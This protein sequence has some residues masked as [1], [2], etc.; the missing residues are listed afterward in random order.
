VELGS[1]P[2]GTVMSAYGAGW[3]RER[4]IPR[5]RGKLVTTNSSEVLAFIPGIDWT[6]A[7]CG[8]GAIDVVPG[9]PAASET[10]VDCGGPCAPCAAGRRCYRPGTYAPDGTRTGSD[11]AANL[12]CRS[13]RTGQEAT[14]NCDPAVETCV[15]LA[16]LPS[17]T[18]ALGRECA[19]GRCGANGRCEAEICHNGKWDKNAGETDIDCG[20]TTCLKRCST[21]TGATPAPQ[22]CLTNA[23]CDGALG[24]RCISARCGLPATEADTPCTSNDGCDA[25]LGLRCINARCGLPATEAD[26]PCTS[27]DGC[28]ATKGLFCIQ[29]VCA[30]PGPELETC[31]ANTDCLSGLCAVPYKATKKVCLASGLAAGSVCSNSQQCGPT[32]GSC[33][34]FGGNNKGTCAPFA[35]D[36]V[37][38]QGESDVDC[39]GVG[40]APRCAA[41]RT[42]TGDDDCD[43]SNNLVCR[44]GKCRGQTGAVV[45]AASACI[46]GATRSSKVGARTVTTCADP[47]CRDRVRNGDETDVDV[48]G[49]ACPRA[50]ESRACRI[51]SD[52]AS[53]RCGVKGQCLKAACNDGIR[54]GNEAAV[55]CGGTCGPCNNG[56]P[57]IKNLVTVCPAPLA[58]ADSN[59]YAATR[60][61]SGRTRWT[62]SPALPA[63]ATPAQIREACGRAPAIQFQCDLRQTTDPANVKPDGTG[64]SCLS[65]PEGEPLSYPAPACASGF[66][67]WSPGVPLEPDASVEEIRSACFAADPGEFRCA[68]PRCDDGRVNGTELDRVDADRECGGTCGPCPVEKRPYRCRAASDCS[69]NIC[70]PRRGRPPRGGVLLGDCQR[71]TNRDGVRN[72][73]ET[74]VDCGG[75]G[76]PPCGIGRSCK[77][78]QDCAGG[79]GTDAAPARN[80]C[81][82][83]EGAVATD[84]EPVVGGRCSSLAAAKDGKKNGAETDIDC[85]GTSG[86]RCPATLTASTATVASFSCSDDAE[87]R[88]KTGNSRATCS[89]GVCVRPAVCIADSDCL[90]GLC[91]DRRKVGK[92]TFGV[93]N[94]ASGSDGIR[95]GLETGRDCGC[96]TRAQAVGEDG[97][98]LTKDGAPVIAVDPATGEQLCASTASGSRF[99]RCSLGGGCGVDD[100]CQTNL[101]TGGVCALPQCVVAASEDAPQESNPREWTCGRN[102]IQRC[103][104][105]LRCLGDV[106]CQSYK[107]FRGTC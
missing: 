40:S 74:D 102:C 52:C 103:A 39:G 80:G 51:D 98:P 31:T 54:N 15:C 12:F 30:A 14:A 37:R 17:G 16:P 7:G 83:A 44:S 38:N 88:S 87:C 46:S 75:T 73:V 101:C 62:P 22:G 13:L 43:A 94:G 33:E 10:D 42:C 59:L 104:N 27:N 24:L 92:A 91:R 25:T 106:D 47:T 9:K 29:S 66:V 4:L 3:T 18:C 71:A 100:D 49:P 69:S 35:A 78:A 96:R 2:D 28:D 72:G 97:A 19:S 70:K 61:S 63:T 56:V 55:D 68:Y 11:C 23:D 50:P 84:D 93:C 26:T 60:C 58:G 36:K 67:N 90:N 20:G 48:G 53:G 79:V 76:N 105:D 41:G 21:S 86:P 65:L 89:N 57:G 99:V 32:G 85:G 8:N 5:G 64:I 81:V 82:D 95:N 107:C 6:Q 45:T 1:V 77:L 34:K